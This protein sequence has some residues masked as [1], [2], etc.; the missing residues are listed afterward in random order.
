MAA[1]TGRMSL[2]FQVS[3]GAPLVEVVG[4]LD[5]LRF[6]LAGVGVSL[7]LGAVALGEAVG[8]QHPVGQVRQVAGSASLSATAAASR[9]RQR[10]WALLH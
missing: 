1:A 4:V 10:R 5:G 7:E 3:G 8:A 9:S 6:E 2:C